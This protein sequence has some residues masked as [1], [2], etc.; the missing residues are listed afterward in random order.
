MLP[1]FTNTP[2]LALAL[3]AR[4]RIVQPR[5][6][7]SPILPLSSPIQRSSIGWG[8]VNTG[9]TYVQGT[10]VTSSET[11]SV[12]SAAS[13]VKPES[14]NSG[15]DLATEEGL[16]EEDDESADS[17]RQAGFT[18]PALASRSPLGVFIPRLE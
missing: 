18:L 14:N 5:M 17:A 7:R 4:V 3:P 10:R 16:K 8:G 12:K 6:T 1:P 11:S 15:G 13:A 9:I 2:P